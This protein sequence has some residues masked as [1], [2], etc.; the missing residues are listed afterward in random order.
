MKKKSLDVSGTVFCIV[1]TCLCHFL[2]PRAE[3]R[4]GISIPFCVSSSTLSL[5]ANFFLSFSQNSKKK[6]IFSLWYMQ[7]GVTNEWCGVH[8][9][10]LHFLVTP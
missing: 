4:M 3:Q 5:K 9:D 2:F 8:N 6:K 1:L 10:Y 7:E